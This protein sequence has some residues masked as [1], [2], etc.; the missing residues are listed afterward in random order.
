MGAAALTADY[1]GIANKPHVRSRL[2]EL[3]CVAELV[4][5]A[6][7][8]AAVTGEKHP[9]GTFLPNMTYVNMGR[10][11]A[12]INVYKELEILTEIAGGL[13]ATLPFEGDFRRRASTWRST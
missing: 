13:P 6:G 4:Y 11:H 3:A 2:A 10:R 5:A 7:I 12:G 9:S 1:Q 8:A